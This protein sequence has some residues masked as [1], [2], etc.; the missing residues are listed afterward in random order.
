MLSALAEVKV[1]E[2]RGKRKTTGYKLK[3]KVSNRG[4]ANTGETVSRLARA[5]TKNDHTHTHT[6]RCIHT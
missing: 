5:R 6:R 4:E 1:Q 2:G 3:K